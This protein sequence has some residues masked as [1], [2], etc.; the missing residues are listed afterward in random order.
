[1]KLVVEMYGNPCIDVLE[2]LPTDTE[3]EIKKKQAKP[4][5][6]QKKAII[7]ISYIDDNNELFTTAFSNPVNYQYDG[8]TIPFHIGKGNMKLLIPALWHDLI[9]EHKEKVA[10]NRKLA[11]LIFKDLLLQCGVNKVLA[12]L[13]YI[14]VDT[15]QRTVK[16]W[17]LGEI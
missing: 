17:K 11:S 6:A 4:F 8:A 7:K 5:I 15:W 16:S 13:M 1:M 10:Y 9:C 14:A 12:H 2:V 3:E